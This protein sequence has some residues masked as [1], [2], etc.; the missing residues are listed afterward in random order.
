MLKEGGGGRGRNG[1]CWGG[2]GGWGRRRG[3]SKQPTGFIHCR[4]SCGLRT[5]ATIQAG[6]NPCSVHDA[7]PETEPADQQAPAASQ[8]QRAGQ[9]RLPQR[10]LVAT[11][12]AD[13]GLPKPGGNRSCC[14]CCCCI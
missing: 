3:G 8:R 13:I 10:Q 14:S 1:V 12:T 4:L 11:A 9:Q 2:V 7:V 5:L 6:S